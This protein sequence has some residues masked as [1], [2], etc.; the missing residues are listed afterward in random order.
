MTTFAQTL[1]RLVGL[2]VSDVIAGGANGS[3]ILLE[4]GGN[5]VLTVY[6]SWRLELGLDVLSG[7][8]ESPDSQTGHL[9]REA[10]NLRHDMVSKVSLSEHYDLQ[11]DFASGKTLRLFC[12]VTPHNEPVDYDEN[13]SF[14]DQAQ[15]HCSVVTNMFCVKEVPYSRCE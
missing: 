1:D 15:D 12:D 8:N 3:I 6:C 9:T 2:A 7:C 4:F 10:K 13:W 5:Y 14:C 11:I